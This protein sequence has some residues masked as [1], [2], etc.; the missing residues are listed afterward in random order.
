ML[1]IVGSCQPPSANCMV[2]NSCTI[3]P[4]SKNSERLHAPAV[5]NMATLVANDAIS[6]SVFSVCSV[7]LLPYCTKKMGTIWPPKHFFQAPPLHVTEDG[8]E[9]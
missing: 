8:P 4:L 3:R 1:S 2:S 6:I 7:L 5:R 9:S